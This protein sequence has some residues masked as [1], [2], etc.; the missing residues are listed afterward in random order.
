MSEAGWIVSLPPSLLSP[1]GTI[2]LTSDHLLAEVGPGLSLLVR[3]EKTKR[4]SRAQKGKVSPR[5][6]TC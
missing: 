6:P 2:S 3:L 5:F 1:S 4:G